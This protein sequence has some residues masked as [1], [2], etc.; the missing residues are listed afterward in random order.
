MKTADDIRNKATLDALSKQPQVYAKLDL[1]YSGYDHDELK[2]D[3]YGEFYA[4][5]DC[6]DVQDVA[7]TETDVS[8]AQLLSADQIKAMSDWCDR[9]LPSAAE[10]R[11]TLK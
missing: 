8:L 4:D 7:L 2:L 1:L 5:D 11:A 6:Y 9:H 10:Q 3:L